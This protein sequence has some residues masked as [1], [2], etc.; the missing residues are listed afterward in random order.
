MENKKILNA[1]P[2]EYNGIKFKSQAETRIYKAI[3]GFG[4]EP[5]YEKYTFVLSPKVRPTIVFY[6]RTKGRGFHQITEPIAKVTYTPDFTFTLNN[7]FVII[8][9]KGIENDTYPIT[10]NLFRKYLESYPQPVMY[11]EIRNK[12]ELTEAMEIIKSECEEVQQI[13]K[14]IPSLQEKDITIANRYLASRDW[15]SLQDLVESTIS[16]IKKSRRKNASPQQKEKYA[17]MN[18]S[19]LQ[20]LS[21]LIMDYSSS[22]EI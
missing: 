11:F 8:E 3:R 1:S 18:L 9:V 12:K 10:K 19:E 17:D 2:N 6:N 13:R 7:I 4:I 20:L 14:L 16:K 15:D 22:L 5:E 21:I